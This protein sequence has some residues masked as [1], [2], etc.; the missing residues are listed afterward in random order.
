MLTAVSSAM[1][2]LWWVL[3]FDLYI[4]LFAGVV[5][6]AG[7]WKARQK[8]LR[9]PLDFKLRRGPGE[10][11]RKKVQSFEE[12]LFFIV[13][14]AGLVPLGVGLFTLQ[15]LVWFAPKTPLKLG[16]GAS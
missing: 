12:N 3:V 13:L 7:I 16:I 15:C 10:S 2:T 1:N 4:L 14:A 9:W 5:L 8:R 6:G 11:L